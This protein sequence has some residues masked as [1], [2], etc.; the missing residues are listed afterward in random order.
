MPSSLTPNMSLVVPTVGQEPGPQYATDINGDLSIVDNHNHTPGFG[1]PVPSAGINYNADI[2]S[3]NNRLKLLKSATFTAQVSPLSGITPD[4]GALY[5]S[6][7]DLYYNDI[8]GIQ[9]RMTQGGGISGTPGSIS[10]LTPPASATY[11]PSGS[12]FIWQSAVNTAAG[13]DN[14]P[15][16]IREEVANAKGITIQSPAS[17][18][19][20]YSLTLPAALPG[21]TQFL[22]ITSA[23][24]INDNVPFP[25]PRNDLAAVGQQ[26]SSSCGSFH[27]TSAGLA[28]VT[29]LTVTITTTGRPVML[30][31]MADQSGTDSYFQLQSTT[32]SNQG[33]MS[34]AILRGASIIMDN[35][36]LVDGGEMKIPPSI[37]YLDPVGAGTYTYKVQAGIDTT[38]TINAFFQF[39]SLYAYELA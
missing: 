33:T 2:N 37:I 1:V 28:D 16:T 4:I 29:N 26:I 31:I 12:E 20:D 19:A 32:G 5:V 8:N 39:L 9:I 23:G 11:S 7:V 15:V 35:V 22:T 14:G 13:M 34:L 6:G 27:V 24:L 17:L 25:L 10:G 30:M 3:N 36:I 21:S 38:N 18:G